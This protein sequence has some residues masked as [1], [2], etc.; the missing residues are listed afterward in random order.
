MNYLIFDNDIYYDIG[1]TTGIAA[2]DKVCELFKEPAKDSIVVIIDTTQKQVAAPEK[3][4]SKI[5]E[6]IASSFSGDYLIIRK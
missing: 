3:S 4:P 6:V 1:G 5:D 2:K